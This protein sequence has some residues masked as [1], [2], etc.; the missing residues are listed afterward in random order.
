MDDLFII[1]T[2]NFQLTELDFLIRM[3]ITTG[4]GFVLGLEREFS[5]FTEKDEVFAG[6][7]TFTFVAL[8]G[9][10]TAFLSISFNYWIFIAGFVSV[11]IIVGVS[12][13][14]TSNN[15]EIGST[16][17]FAT[18][19]TFLL[20][21]LTFL[22]FINASLALTVVAIV[23][24]SLKLKLRTLISQLTQKE[25]Y[26]FVRFVI[27]ALLILPFL[28]DQNFGPFNVINP[29][30]I[31][32]VIVLT[33]GIGFVGYI[34]IKFI[35]SD[36]GLILTGIL[37]G[38]VSSTLVTFIFSKKSVENPSYSYNY[39]VG[40]FAS[41]TTM[42]VRVGLLVFIFNEVMLN[43]L[44]L[45]LAI[46]FLTAFSTTLFFYKKHQSIKTSNDKLSLGDP[47]DIKSAVFFGVFYI[48]ILILVS[49]ASNLYGDKGI[50]IS[51]VISSL[52]DIDA[53]AISVSKFGGTSIKLLT[54]QNAILFATLS[55]TIVKI[56]ITVWI[57]S[58]NL[59]KY[60]LI[61]YSFIFMA[62]IIGFLILNN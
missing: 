41:A 3:L 18:I 43:K 50:Y 34:L 10:L 12:Y 58:K 57:G 26:A 40:I 5:Q 24:L 2:E 61:G 29:R 42:A 6:I 54:A 8:L 13:W 1:Q 59:K 60:V 52:T 47:L 37:G 55:N 46:I 38:I 36:K 19:F 49:Y 25:I 30:E 14:V 7:R 62:G 27:I 31:G 32:W 11:V 44:L 53:I 35:G 56:G 33:S 9:F 15:G 39:A 21:G 22:G 51:S 23:I 48:G 17:E 20:G 16:T 45:P 4:I 28:P